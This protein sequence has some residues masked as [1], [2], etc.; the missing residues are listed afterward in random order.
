MST[1]VPA[2]DE[3][4]DLGAEILAR[5]NPHMSVTFPTSYGSME[6]RNDCAFHGLT[7]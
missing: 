4:A 2:V 7:P 3:G 1:V 6:N 5:Y